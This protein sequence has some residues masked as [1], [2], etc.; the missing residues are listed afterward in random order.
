MK[1][2]ADRVTEGYLRR[3]TEG[4]AQ[5]HPILDR[6]EKTMRSV[7]LC[8]IKYVPAGGST[9]WLPRVLGRIVPRSP[10]QNK[11]SRGHR[12]VGSSTITT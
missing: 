9:V 3:V 11:E 2:Q 7:G 6:A 4:T 8:C 1:S 10:D 5:T 12:L